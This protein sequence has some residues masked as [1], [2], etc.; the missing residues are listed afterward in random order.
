MRTRISQVV[1]GLI[2]LAL[3]G[4]ALPAAPAAAYTETKT[5]ATKTA[6]YM[7]F[8]R[9]N[10]APQRGTLTAYAS[11]GSTR[12]R[13]SMRAGTGSGVVSECVRNKGQIPVGFYDP[14]DEDSNSTLVYISNKTWGNSVI[15]GAVWSL[16]NKVCHPKAGEKRITRTDLFIHSEGTSGWTENNYKSN[17]CI[18]VN[19]TDRAQLKKRWSAAYRRDTGMLMVY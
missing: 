2:C 17:G 4:A 10:K 1:T 3:A 18:K 11:V 9:N 5:T 14:R 16:G 6:P 15:R 12:Y 7:V 8:Q 19:Q 13:V